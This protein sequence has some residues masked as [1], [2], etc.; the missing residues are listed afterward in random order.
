[1]MGSIRLEQRPIKTDDLGPNLR[2][3]LE[4][5]Q[6]ELLEGDY[7]GPDKIMRFNIR[8]PIIDLYYLELLDPR[9][10]WEKH[11]GYDVSFNKLIKKAVQ[12]YLALRE[13]YIVS[14]LKSGTR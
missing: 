13:I 11:A 4:A 2:K 3:L 6:P 10:D 1:M 7:I 12:Q 9:S 8:V 14:G 5:R